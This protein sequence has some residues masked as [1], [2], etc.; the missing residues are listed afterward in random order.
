MTTDELADR[1]RAVA[2]TDAGRLVVRLLVWVREQVALEGA[3][4]PGS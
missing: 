1:L 4:P 3:S 2:G